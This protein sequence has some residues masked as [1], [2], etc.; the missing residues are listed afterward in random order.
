MKLVVFMYCTI[1]SIFPKEILPSAVVFKW[2][3]SFL[4]YEIIL[5]RFIVS[6]IM[7]SFSH[8]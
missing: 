2:D 8:Q 6:I 7:N 1:V 5:L 4:N 3:M